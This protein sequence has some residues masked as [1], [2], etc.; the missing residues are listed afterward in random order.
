L[1][2]RAIESS[3][4]GEYGPTHKNSD[5]PWTVERQFRRIKHYEQLPLLIAALHAKMTT[6]TDAAA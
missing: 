5:R 3:H 2:V 4:K 1:R 6:T